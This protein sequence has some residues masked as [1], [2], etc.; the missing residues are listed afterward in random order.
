M[1]QANATCV[2]AAVRE[3]RPAPASTGSRLRSILFFVGDGVF[4][5]VVGAVAAV[6]MRLIDSLGWNA[7]LTWIVGMVL[8]MLA[9]TV[10][11]F[12]AAPLLGSIETMVPSMVVAMICPMALDL[13]EMMGAD[14]GWSWSIG[15]GAG[16]GLAMFLY[17]EG[18]GVRCRRSLHRI[19][20]PR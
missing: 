16:L 7:V 8:A 14:L 5:V 13:L 11:A 2:S 12:A 20:L 18:Y 1:A 15:F 3:A 6:A 9:Q 10:L 4:L 17:V 19:G